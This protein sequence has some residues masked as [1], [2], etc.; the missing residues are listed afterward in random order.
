MTGPCVSKFAQH[1][2][3]YLAQASSTVLN[4]DNHWLIQL[5]NIQ[6]QEQVRR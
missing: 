2:T 6:K 5:R 4:E 3:Q 1:H